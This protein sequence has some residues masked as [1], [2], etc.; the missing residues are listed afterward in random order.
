MEI[1]VKNFGPIKSGS[2]D[3]SKRFYVFVGHNNSGKTYMANLVWSACN[4]KNFSHIRDEITNEFIEKYQENFTI[5]N[6]ET[7]F[8]I[9][10]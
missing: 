7:Q 5:V 1:A 8:I 10:R 6:N 3:L 2:I 4:T 9:N